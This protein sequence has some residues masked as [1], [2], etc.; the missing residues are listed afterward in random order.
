MVSSSFKQSFSGSQKLGTSKNL[1]LKVG[2]FV[3]VNFETLQRKQAKGFLYNNNNQCA[4]LV[5]FYYLVK[6]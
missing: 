6:F 2:Q 3:L 1:F 4:K 5:F